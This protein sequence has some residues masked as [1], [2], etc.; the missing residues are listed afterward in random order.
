MGGFKLREVKMPLPLT[1]QG[2]QSTTHIILLRARDQGFVMPTDYKPWCLGRILQR[3]KQMRWR[4]SL[5]DLPL[6][7]KLGHPSILPSS[8]RNLFLPFQKG[9]HWAAGC[10]I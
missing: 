1:S 9:K 5:L 8:S 7:I 10:R 6:V 2:M 3:V 4:L